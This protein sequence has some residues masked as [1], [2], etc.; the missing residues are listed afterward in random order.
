M[1][2]T[3]YRTFFVSTVWYTAL[4]LA[5]FDILSFFFIG[6]IAYRALPVLWDHRGG[7][8]NI[9][10]CSYSMYSSLIY[11]SSST[12]WRNISVPRK[13]AWPMWA[14]LLLLQWWIKLNWGIVRKCG[15]LKYKMKNGARRVCANFHKVWHERARVVQAQG[16]FFFLFGASKTTHKKSWW[17]Q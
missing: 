5:L 2:S 13:T 6:M 10:K 4:L 15:D 17:P 16:T 14:C 8:C 11:S 1:G 3:V 7:K 12:A 9:V